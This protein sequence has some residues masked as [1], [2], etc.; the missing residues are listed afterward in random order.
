MNEFLILLEFCVCEKLIRPM[1]CAS[2]KLVRDLSL[3]LGLLQLSS[4]FD[5]IST[6]MRDYLHTKLVNDVQN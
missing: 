1:T 3:T 5:S 4:L 2:V 6:L